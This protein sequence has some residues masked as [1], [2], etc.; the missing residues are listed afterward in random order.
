MSNTNGTP[1]QAGVDIEP[2]LS[3]HPIANVTF[4]NCTAINN[5]G[6]G[7]TVALYQMSGKLPVTIK[8]ENCSVRGGARSGFWFQAFVPKLSKGSV[9][10]TGGTVEETAEFGLAV[11]NKAAA[12]VPLRVIGLRLRGTATLAPAPFAARAWPDGEAGTIPFGVENGPVAILKRP[13]GEPIGPYAEGNIFLENLDVQDGDQTRPW[14]QIVGGKHGMTGITG[15][16]RVR[17]T[18]GCF[19]TRR[20]ASNASTNVHTSCSLATGDTESALKLD[21][22]T[23]SRHAANR[24]PDAASVD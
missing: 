10:V 23:S 18:T 7:F 19:I 8:F 1:P 20:N 3:T 6:H 21:D 9:T 15:S 24:R 16:A 11:S 22:T 13:R 2:S 12:S 4:R 14:L 17:D 5:T